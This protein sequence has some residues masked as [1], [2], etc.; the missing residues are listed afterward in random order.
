[1][2]PE[3]ITLLTSALAGRYRVERELGHGGMAVVFL[4]ED[5]KHRRRV[6]LKVLRPEVAQVHRLGAVP[7]GNRDRRPA[8]PSPHPPALRQRGG[9]KA[10]QRAR[11]FLFFV[12]PFVEGESLRD[13]LD[14]EKQLPL[15]DALRVAREVADALAYAHRLG[16]VH[17]DIKPENILLQAGHPVV[18]DFGIASALQ[19]AVDE[20]AHRSRLRRGYAGLHE[21]GAVGRRSGR[22]PRSDVYSLGLR[23]VRD[24]G[25]R[26]R[27]SPEPRPRRSRR[28]RRRQRAAAPHR[29][30][31]RAG[32][33]RSS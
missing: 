8:Q 5:V 13:R 3:D 33:R 18:S 28:G 14:R 20:Q 19:A 1:M 23:A 32:G 12:M 30:G 22:T 10:G 25:G 7:P 11:A 24:A 26:R 29:A 6:A 27:P 15:D 16:I 21:P 17:R 4:A 2:R 9:G 31:E